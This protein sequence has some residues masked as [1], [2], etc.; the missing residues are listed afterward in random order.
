M[1]CSTD[2]CRPRRQ[3]TV[4]P[5]IIMFKPAIAISFAALLASQQVLACG[6]HMYL[7]PEQYGFIGG[8]VIKMAGLAPPEPTFKIEHAPTTKVEIG[9]ESAITISYS[10]PWR[11]ENVKIKLNGTSN[12]EMIDEELSLEELEGEVTARFKLLRPGYNSIK[13]AISGDHKGEPVVQHSIVYV[14]AKANDSYATS[15]Q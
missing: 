1:A 8:T 6:Y 13:I 2:K 11:S 9:A 3:Q 14:G 10:R 12:I 7:D 15:S 5:G 4:R